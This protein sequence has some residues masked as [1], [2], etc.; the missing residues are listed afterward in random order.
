MRN[1]NF[2]CMNVKMRNS[3]Q[4]T[5]RHRQRRQIPPCMMTM[6]YFLRRQ[7]DYNIK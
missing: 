7:C 2:Y 1:K 3:K 4:F 5:P 6:M